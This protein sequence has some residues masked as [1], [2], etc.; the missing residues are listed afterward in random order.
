M[1][2][3]LTPRALV[4]PERLVLLSAMVLSARSAPTSDQDAQQLARRAIMK[5]DGD[6]YVPLGNTKVPLTP[7]LLIF[8]AFAVAILG[9]LYAL[10]N[11]LCSGSRFSRNSRQVMEERA[12]AKTELRLKGGGPRSGNSPLGSPGPGAVRTH[13]NRHSRQLNKPIRGLGKNTPPSSSEEKV[14]PMRSYRGTSV[15]LSDAVRG[16]HA[17][18][19]S[20][21]VLPT[22]HATESFSG[23]FSAAG[24]SK[25]GA[26]QNERSQ[27][28]YRYA[29]ERYLAGTAAGQGGQNL[30]RTSSVGRGT[31]LSRNRSLQGRG[32]PVNPSAVD[33][34]YSGAVDPYAHPLD[35]SHDLRRH[36]T[37]PQGALSASR[38]NSTLSMLDSSSEN[39]QSESNFGSRI[40]SM[41]SSGQHYQSPLQ[42]LGS[43]NFNNSSFSNLPSGRES[44]GSGAIPGYLQQQQQQQTRSAARSY[45]RDDSDAITSNS[46]L[47]GGAGVVPSA[48][49]PSARRAL[50]SSRPG[51]ASP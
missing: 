9:L 31:D 49:N 50:A 25:D 37:D 27:P 12:R 40:P 18:S 39:G 21:L 11:V 2:G 51:Y 20:M 6:E 45:E 44:R 36:F 46:G 14:A 23:S 10:L 29:S 38:R 32:I 26:A 33:R 28:P 41:A 19:G 3:S 7:L 4:T 8:S 42:P 34:T 35:S 24:S 5:S 43:P 48:M 22:L 47:L 17:S 13:P 16:G 30:N 1:R 15:S